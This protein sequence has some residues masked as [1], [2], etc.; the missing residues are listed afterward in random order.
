MKYKI[1]KQWQVEHEETQ[2]AIVSFN[3][4]KKDEEG[5]DINY[6]QELCN[7]PLDENRLQEKLTEYG[8]DYEKALS[9]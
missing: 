4:G 6:E 1:L 7:L 3:F 2:R 8:N 9:V 5:N